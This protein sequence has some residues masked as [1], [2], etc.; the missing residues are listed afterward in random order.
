MSV[1]RR[2]SS[3]IL[4]AIVMSVTSLGLGAPASAADTPETA[5]N[6]LLDAVGS[7]DLTGLEALV[8][9]AERGAVR[10]M[11]DIGAQ[12][13]L[14]AADSATQPLTFGIS[15]RSTEL[16]DQADDA[17]TV[18]VTGTLTVD[19]DE[20]QLRDLVRA[21]LEADQGPDDPPVS[22]EDLDFMLP[23]I[24]SAFS[25]GQP[26]DEEVTLVLED[27]GWLVCGGL[28]ESTED[29]DEFP[30][31][32]SFDGLCG[33][34]TVDQ[35]SSLGVL[36]YDSSQGFETTCTYSLSSYEEYHSATISLN[37]GYSIEDFAGVLG[38]D[39]ATSVAGNDAFRSSDQL[40]VQVGDDVLQ[41]AL[42]LG[43]EPRPDVD[44]LAHA[45]QVAELF[46]PVV[47]ELQLEEPEVTVT[48][49]PESPSLC[50][51][52]TVE[53]VNALGPMQYDQVE[54]SEG[55]CSYTTTSTEGGFAYLSV[56]LDQALRLDDLK[57]LFP[58]GEDLSVSG[59]TAYAALGQLWIE[60]DEGVLTI[61]GVSALDDGS[62]V[63][64][65]IEYA[66]SVAELVIATLAA[67]AG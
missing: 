42:Y 8:C 29:P 21:M 15:D 64:D 25:S 16:L 4:V 34:V 7:G 17:A 41:V 24:S 1:S 39:E 43:E 23:L 48:P 33:L 19:V 56:S 38:A 45:S 2:R 51:S 11:F 58:D 30:A 65:P 13:G 12:L 14:P 31:Q 37:E 3:G 36:E 50:E 9:E 26:I 61:A 49:E 27:G 53:A 28:G 20:E 60:L 46:I 47:G 18:R 63:V 66:V 67:E 32:V 10:E 35:M 44:A 5:V 52:L 6:E 62:P 59:R 57:T 40:L 22:D 54:G 55:Y